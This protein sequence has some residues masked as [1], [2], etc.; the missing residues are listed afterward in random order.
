M[1]LQVLTTV[2]EILSQIEMIKFL[3][4]NMTKERY[5]SFLS[6]MIP[7]NYKQV[8]V[9]SEDKCIGLTG[10]WFGTKLWTGKYLEIDNFIV[11]PDYRKNGIG[12]LLTNFIDE[13][14]KELNCTC[15][16][17]DAFTGNFDAHRFYY[18]QGYVPRGF[19][20]IKTIDEKGY[21]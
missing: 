18:N 7:K 12:K 16:V 20:F 3:Y 2:D 14:A 15:V 1:K 10:F 13:K 11:H 5:E 19:H 8:A 6:D 9:F 17:L 4:P 21:S